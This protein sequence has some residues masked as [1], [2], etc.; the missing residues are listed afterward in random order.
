MVERSRR[1]FRWLLILWF[2]I[3]IVLGLA[4][5]NIPWGNPNQTHGIGLPIPAVIF[6]KLPGETA[7]TDYPAPLALILNPIVILAAGYAVLAIIYLLVHALK[8]QLPQDPPS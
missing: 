7:F 6:K 1:V 8:K 4:A 2:P 5:S 3:S